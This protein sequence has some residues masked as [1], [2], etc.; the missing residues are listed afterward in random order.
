MLEI[1]IRN[2]RAR[3]TL[4]PTKAAIDNVHKQTDCR[5]EELLSTE[6]IPNNLREKLRGIDSAVKAALIESSSASSPSPRKRSIRDSPGLGL[7][8]RTKPQPMLSE[9]SQPQEFVD[10]LN[11]Q[12]CSAIKRRAVAKL[13][14]L[15]RNE[16]IAW[17]DEFVHLHGCEAIVRQ[18]R[19]VLNI[20]WRDDDDDCLLSDL[21]GCLKS[22]CTSDR[23]LLA[24]G[25]VAT[26][27]LP[28]LVDFL[29]SEKGPAE[30]S[31]RQSI[32]CILDAH[33]EGDFGLRHTRAE[34]IL[35]YLADPLK[36]LSERHPDFMEAAYTPRPYKRWVAELERVCRDVFWIFL[37]SSNM[38]D[39]L[40]SEQLSKMN[41]GAPV[42]PQGFVG[43]VEWEATH[44]M[45]SYIRLINS[46]LASLHESERRLLRTE[47]KRSQFETIMGQKLRKAST[48]FYG[49]LHEELTIWVSNAAHDRWNVSSIVRASEAD[50]RVKHKASDHKKAHSA[51]IPTLKFD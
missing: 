41:R 15:L 48:K 24:L 6:N 20:E 35:S 34:Q 14:L 46:I 45:A 42:V 44:Y 17:V 25:S 30:F 1:K 8:K 50:I 31:T 13:K 27:I 5:F 43:G 10:F 4:T 3:L 36:P 32:M 51:Q 26:E 9:L 40:D 11:R 37:H 19:R 49:H 28:T 21:L 18:I 47:M 39:V 16:R 33:L 2:K 22:L 29:F 38:I 12:D 23:G 7:P